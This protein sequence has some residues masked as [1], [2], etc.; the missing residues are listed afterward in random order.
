MPYS[1]LATLVVGAHL[2]FVAFVTAGGWLVLRRPRLAWVHL[3]C[4]AWGAYVE[5]SGRL[6]PLTPLENWLRRR[7]GEAGYE[8]GFIEHY[9][10]AVVYPAGLDRTF[11]LVAGAVVVAVNVGVYAALLRRRAG[12]I[13]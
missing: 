5:W 1:L 8:E 13:G 10:L 12:R 11:Q 7:A 3:P 9:L 6:C 4:A 2:L